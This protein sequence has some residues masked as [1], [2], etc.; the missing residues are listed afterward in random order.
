MK[1]FYLATFVSLYIATSIAGTVCSVQA[2]ELG[3]DI[4]CFSDPAKKIQLEFRTYSDE[5][6]GWVGGQVRYGQ[7]KKFIPLV[8]KGSKTVM[9]LKDR[10]SEFKHTWLE[11][12][13]S[14]ISGKY[15]LNSQGANVYGFSYT[16]HKT[17]KTTNLPVASQLDEYGKCVWK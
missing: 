9:D 17:G 3:V 1:L 15:Q 16:S 12:V 6:I 14:A 13:D 2:K 10:P 5:G 8:F 11:V 7:S 4:R